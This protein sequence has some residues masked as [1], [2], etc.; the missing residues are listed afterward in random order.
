MNEAPM[1]PIGE[2]KALENG[3]IKQAQ[4]RNCS[5]NGTVTYNGGG[6]IAAPRSGFSTHATGRAGL[7][8]LT[9]TATI[10]PIAGEYDGLVEPA[11]LEDVSRLAQM[12]QDYMPLRITGRLASIVRKS[13]ACLPR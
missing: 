3:C 1:P 5:E 7:E 6:P 9:M 8:E 2:G 13:R 4:K 12:G 10:A 11:T